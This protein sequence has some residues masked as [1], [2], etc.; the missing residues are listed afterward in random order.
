MSFVMKKKP[1]TI[2]EKQQFVYLPSLCQAT[3]G[4]CTAK[5]HTGVCSPL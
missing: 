3:L 4:L 2:T 5:C 1:E